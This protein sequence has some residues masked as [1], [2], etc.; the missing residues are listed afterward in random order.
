MGEGL[1]RRKKH[2]FVLMDDG[3]DSD[4]GSFPERESRWEQR[5]RDQDKHDIHVTHQTLTP[6][7]TLC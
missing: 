3:W 7:S 4:E 5:L 1:S 2:E 6:Y